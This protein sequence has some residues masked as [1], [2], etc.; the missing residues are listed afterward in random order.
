[1]AAI[2]PKPLKR[3]L[4][5]PTA[6]LIGMG[7]AI[8]SGIFRT[9]GE[10]AGPLQTPGLILLAWTLGGLVILT[11][12]LVTA[13]LATRFPQA[14]G[15]YVFLREAYGRFVAFFFGWAY[16]FC[17]IGAGAATI[18]AAFGDFSCGLFSV[19]PSRS[20]LFAAGAIVMVTGINA[21]GLRVG[22]AVQNVVTCLKIAALL[23]IVIIGFALGSRSLTSDPAPA[24]I[25]SSAPGLAIFLAALLP[26]LWS[27][28][29]AT[30]AVKLAEEVR[31]VRR[32]LPRAIIGG[33]IALMVLYLAVNAALMCVVAPSEMAG[34]SS[35]PGEAM[36]RLFGHNGRRAMLVVGMFACLGCL[37]STILATIR[38]TFAL[39]RDG[40]TF[41]FMAHMSKSQAPVPALL[42]VAAF[43]IFL[44]LNRSFSEVL[45]IY[46]FASAFLFGLAYASLIV[47]RL[48]ESS[49]PSTVFRCPWGMVLAGFLILK[50]TAIASSIAYFSPKDAMYTTGLLA[51]LG[52]LYFVWRRV[53]PARPKSVS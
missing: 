22:A 53:V 31:D 46:Y 50:E 4:G 42:V 18:A 41:R 16:T 10:V 40:L 45:R 43:A 51:S 27:Y 13:E 5:A 38:V 15:E 7:V 20:G 9:P 44:V 37:S 24:L 25:A 19:S 12:G 33:T 2:H 11:Q 48:R 52:L 26:V 17:V 36:G 35:V 39:A 1:M 21:I 14:G 28:D 23:G 8:G 29:G 32:N 3:I 49:F 34:V 6:L 47:F 30:D